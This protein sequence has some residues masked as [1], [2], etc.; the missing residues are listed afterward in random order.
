[1]H[2][3][4]EVRSRLE[5]VQRAVTHDS[6]AVRLVAPQNLHLTLHFLG[7]TDAEV[8]EPLVEGLRTSIESFSSFAATARG[9]G[10]FPSARKPRVFWAGV[11]A[12]NGADGNAGPL[13][14]IHAAAG[15]VLTGLDFELDRRPFSP[16]ITIGYARKKADP[17]ELTEAAGELA[18]AAREQ[19]GE[20]G[21]G[22]RVEAIALVESTLGRGG[23]TYTDIETIPLRG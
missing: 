10:C 15:T 11:E 7:D 22:F 16:H 1:M 3:S 17:S 4:E 14:R 21:T 6:K 19:L 2:L 13:S 20:G 9:G 5:A 18:A 12:E 8:V 23:P